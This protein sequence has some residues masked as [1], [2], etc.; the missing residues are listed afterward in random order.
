MDGRRG[1]SQANKILTTQLTLWCEMFTCKLMYLFSSRVSST[2]LIYYLRKKDGLPDAKGP[3]S[4]SIDSRGLNLSSIKNSCKSFR[5]C[6]CQ[7][8]SWSQGGCF[9]D[10]KV[11]PRYGLLGRFPSIQELWQRMYSLL[12]KIDKYSLWL[13]TK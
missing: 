9:K 8:L 5:K 13:C 3:L 10:S 6:K 2:S 12:N 11:H 1:S 7:D 4:E